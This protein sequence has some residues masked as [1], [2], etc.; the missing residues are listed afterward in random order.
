[1]DLSRALFRDAV[2]LF[3][4]STRSLTRRPILTIVAVLTLGLGIGANTAMFSLI[5]V[6]FLKPLP[7]READ[8]LAMVMSTRSDQQ[9]DQGFSSYPDFKD[10]RDRTKAFSG[11]AALWTFANGDV[12][13]G[14]GTEPQRVSVARVT[15]D[16]FTVLGIR[17]LYGRS[18]QEEE[19]IVG[20]HRRA[21][22]SYGLWRQ[23]FGGDTSLVGRSVM[24]NGVPYT[25]VGIMPPDLAT[26]AVHILGTDVQLWRPLVPDDNQTG[27][28]GSR[29]LRVVGRLAPGVSLAQAQAELS[30]IAVRLTE[31]YP[32]TNR[33]VG[34]QVAPLREQI[35]KDVRRGL[36]FLFGAVALVLLGACANVANLLLIKAASTRKQLAVQYALGASRRRLFAQ[37]F[38][39]A[40][41]LGGAGAVVGTLLAFGIVRAFVA[42]GPGD[43]P[44]LADARIDVAVLSFTIFVTLIAVF[45]AALLPAW[46]AA[47][48]DNA[49]LLR[50]SAS[51]VR[52]RD[53]R[54]AMRVLTA[55]QIALAM[56]LLTVGGLLIRSF[57]AL[58]RVDPGI[59][60]VGVLTFQIELPMASTA[61]YPSQPQRDAFFGTLLQRI[62]AVPEVTGAAIASSPPMEEE[63]NESSL[64][65]PDDPP[66]TARQAAFRMVS[67]NYFSLMRIPILAGRSFDAT[68]ARS[69][70]DVVIVSSA[71]ARAVWGKENPVGKRIALSSQREA[72]VIGIAGDVRIAGLASEPGRTV[73]L[74]TTQGTFN[75]M[76]LLVKTRKNPTALIPVVRKLVH[77]QDGAV[78]LHHVRTL[79]AIVA[80]S[81]SHQR[82]QMLLVTAFSAL[83]LVLAIIGIYGVTAYAVSERT[84]ELGVRAA[85]GA[86]SADIR[87]LVLVEGLR[88]AGAGI[89]IGAAAALGA[90][91][92]L[93]RF[94][95]HISAIDPLS[96]LVSPLILAGTGLLATFLPAWRA[97]QI[98]PVSALRAE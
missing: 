54:R 3:A 94:I 95:F 33:N 10:L 66:G 82:F 27:G 77:E 81:V 89:V 98:D 58:L 92:A 68:D 91:G 40:L 47:Q 51:R 31:L 53:D 21:I 65:L 5:N 2:R 64:R 69:A 75:F 88:L 85:L 71:L 18:F 30:S 70:P 35:V 61:P 32:D 63:P 42:F 37:V 39:E 6:V 4:Y 41:L 43:I 24:V 97:S 15:P 12:N 17:P 8:R 79:D 13:L 44:L 62:G 25:V 67:P 1:M 20:N 59:D 38:A 87:R 55:T 22:L 60:P 45:L 48:P 7:F 26:R 34:V 36:L 73:Y 9:L 11:L 83:M 80:A 14:G 56:L 90:S 16:F 96:F 46:R 49:I 84:N 93:S 74:T 72:E 50:Q 78:P 57:D 86:T 52:G 29:K 19:T 76:T 28:R 23:Q